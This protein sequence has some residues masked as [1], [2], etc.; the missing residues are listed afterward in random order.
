M[1]MYALVHVCVYLGMH[2]PMHVC[3]YLFM[4]VRVYVCIRACVYV[5]VQSMYASVCMCVY[6]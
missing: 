2:L 6:I 1:P 5:G 3:A 4:C